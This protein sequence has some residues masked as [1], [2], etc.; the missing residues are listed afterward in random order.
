VEARHEQ[1]KLLVSEGKSLPEIKQQLGEPD[2][3]VG[4]PPP[5]PNFP[6]YTTVVYNELSKKTLQ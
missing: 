4:A 2:P 6:T 3:P 1:I 5:V